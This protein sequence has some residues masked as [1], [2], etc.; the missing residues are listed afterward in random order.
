M[1]QIGFITTQSGSY[2]TFRELSSFAGSAGFSTVAREVP[3][4]WSSCTKLHNFNSFQLFII[5]KSV[6]ID[7]VQ[8]KK[9][10]LL[11]VVK[12]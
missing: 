6:I 8:I 1:L 11:G 3:K 7:I 4:I 9:K 2:A 5:R 12:Q 10:T